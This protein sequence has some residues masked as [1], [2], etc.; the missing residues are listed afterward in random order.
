M[1]RI[2]NAA[3]IVFF[4]TWDSRVT[5]IYV[6]GDFLFVLKMRTYKKYLQLLSQHYFAATMQASSY[7]RENLDPV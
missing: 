4:L 2:T 5:G 3:A 7:G 6:S 1:K